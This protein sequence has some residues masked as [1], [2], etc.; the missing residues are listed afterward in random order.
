[1]TDSLA[2]RVARLAGAEREEEERSF[3]RPEDD[4]VAAGARLDLDRALDR[5]CRERGLVKPADALR[6]MEM[7]VEALA[8]W[9]SRLNQEESP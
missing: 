5:H 4:A 8:A 6:L 9:S 2:A 7:H 3:S 1:M